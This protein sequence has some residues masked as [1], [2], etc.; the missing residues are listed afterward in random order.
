VEGHHRQ[1]I[2]VLRPDPFTS[3][4]SPV[5]IENMTD[6]YKQEILD[7]LGEYPDCLTQKEISGYHPPQTFFG[8]L[9]FLAF[10]SLSSSLSSSS[11]P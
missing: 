11:R 5:E 3:F 6:G 4:K 7:C 1:I 8:L 10:L 2:K 9:A